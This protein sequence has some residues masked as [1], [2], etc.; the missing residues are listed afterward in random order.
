MVRFLFHHRLQTINLHAVSMTMSRLLIMRHSS[1]QKHK[2]QQKTRTTHGIP[3][4]TFVLQWLSSIRRHYQIHVDSFPAT[5]S[6][7]THCW[8][9]LLS[10]LVQSQNHRTVKSNLFDGTSTTPYA[11]KREQPGPF[12]D[13]IDS[14]ETTQPSRHSSSIRVFSDSS[15]QTRC[16]PTSTNFHLSLN[17]GDVLTIPLRSAAI[18]PGASQR[19]R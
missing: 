13:P 10:Q 14:L 5:P 8:H 4:D 9:S 17:T 12:C 19:P 7:Y 11:L 6:Q 1:V 3:T 2:R 16:L 15:D 18:L